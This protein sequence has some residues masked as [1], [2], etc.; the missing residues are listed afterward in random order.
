MANLTLT[1]FDWVPEMPRGFVRDL[2]VRWSLE[3]AALP[4]RVASVPFDDRGPAH[5]AHQP[6]G[7]VPWLTDGDLSIFE[8]GAILLHLGERSDKLMPS[9]PR[10]R[11]EA[12]KWVFAALNSVEMASLPWAMLKFMGNADDTPAWKFLD[13]FLG[14]RLKHLELVLARREWLAGSFSVADILMSDVLR[15]VDRFEGLANHPACRAYLAR[16]TARP[17]FAKARADQMAHFAAADKA[18]S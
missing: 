18:R 11:V 12:T 15:P 16:A 6:F 10:G 14:V 17:A 13:G 7:Q 9:D 1:T 5:L 8:S 4:Y 2:R 3:E